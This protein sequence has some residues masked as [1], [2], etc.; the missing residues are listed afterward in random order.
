MK[1]LLLA[2]LILISTQVFGQFQLRQVLPKQVTGIGSNA[3]GDFV[4]LDSNTLAVSSYKHDLIYVYRNINDVWKAEQVLQPADSTGDKYFG[5]R[6]DV[7]GNTIMAGASDDND[8]LGAVYFF[9]RSSDGD[10]TQT[11]KITS[12]VP[13]TPISSAYWG[14]RHVHVHGDM[15]TAS[16]NNGLNNYFHMLS[17]QTDDTWEI[18]DS[19]NTGS[20]NYISGTVLHLSDTL[21]IV[22]GFSSDP[23]ALYAFTREGPG[24]TWSEPETITP[25]NS[26]TIKGFGKYMAVSGHNMLV[27]SPRED[28]VTG[29]DTLEEAGKIY[30][31]EQ[32]NGSWEET[33]QFTAGVPHRGDYFG[34]PVAI[35]NDVF[36]AGARLHDYDT[37]GEDSI[38]S[39][40]AVY[41]FKKING[42]W[43]QTQKI[44]TYDRSSR[45]RFGEHLALDNGIIAIGAIG[46]VY[47]FHEDED[48]MGL[49]QGEA[50]YDACYTCA[51]GTSGNTPEL[52]LTPDN[53]MVTQINTLHQKQSPAVQIL[54]NPFGAAGF[55]LHIPEANVKQITI[56]D[57][58]GQI[59]FRASSTEQLMG[60]DLSK[61]M[62]LLTITFS[63]GESKVYKILRH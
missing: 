38:T 29:E 10:W 56:R 14:G 57:V 8:N 40:G 44:T 23:A 49:A 19:L 37:Q 27:S 50:F 46:M 21:I 26:E 39:A 47:I 15:A 34:D 3:F 2:V 59:H 13:S 54:P 63:G 43:E 16:R 12:P 42:N 61:G 11:T 28:V 36:V 25:R 51:G 1:K 33:Q 6:L 48:C 35:E 20:G 22:P 53:C 31:F 58:N 4:A 41:V 60:R 55:H 62:Y 45:Q 9:E 5:Y 32:Q 17:K 30:L 18:T 7:S 52:D 24:D